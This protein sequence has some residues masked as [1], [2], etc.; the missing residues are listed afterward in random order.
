MREVYV[1]SSKMSDVLMAF[2]AAD[3][4]ELFAAQFPAVASVS[5]SKV[6]FI[7]TRDKATTAADREAI[8]QAI[9][10]ELKA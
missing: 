5:V 9:E 4:A 7:A 8:R 3:D 10:K 2:E 6:Y 1:V